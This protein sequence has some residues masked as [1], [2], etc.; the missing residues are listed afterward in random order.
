MSIFDRIKIPRA[1]EHAFPAAA[2]LGGFLWDSITLGKMVQGS[3]LWMMFGY[4]VISFGVLLMLALRVWPPKWESR[5]TWLVQFCFGSIFS[6]MV[7]C[8]FKSSGSIY[9]L[10]FVLILV[11]VL[12]ANE[13]LQNKYTKITLSWSLLCLSGSMYLNFQLPYLVHSVG[14]VWFLLSCALAFLPAWA[15]WKLSKRDR[16]S[17]IP[18]AF[19][20]IG[21][22]LCW[23]LDLIPPVPMVLKQTII[24]KGFERIS[25]EYTCLEP[26]Q[27]FMKT[28]FGLGDFEIYHAP[29]EVIY[30]LS[31]VFGPNDLEAHLEHRWK[32]LD[33][34]GEWMERGRVPFTMRGGRISGWR[35]Y[36]NKQSLEPGF[37]RLETALRDG[38]V[39][40]SVEFKVP[41]SP[42]PAGTVYQRVPLK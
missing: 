31:S 38:A 36:S 3:D 34:S 18:P 39:I 6:A 15:V 35:L 28:H 4:W 20:T 5:I 7:V 8:Y 9:T 40:G 2:F 10:L 14:T 30:A 29:G 13:F 33:P 37:W 26:E 41:E 23:F 25:G 1:L 22:V 11:A 24:C 17:L 21:L 42:E 19:V 32:W 12:V 16:S 27:S